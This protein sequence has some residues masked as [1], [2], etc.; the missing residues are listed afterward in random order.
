MS[1]NDKVDQETD[2]AAG[3]SIKAQVRQR[4]GAIAEQYG[5]ASQATPIEFADRPPQGMSGCCGPVAIS[6]DQV[7]QG[8]SCCAPASG[9]EAAATLAEALYHQGDLADL[10]AGVTDVSL[11][12]GNPTAIAQLKPGETVLDLGSGGGIDCFIAAKKVGSAGR[13]IGVDMTGSMLALANQNKARL[14]LTNVEFRKGEIE[15]LPVQNDSVDVVISNCVINLSPDKPAVFGEIYRV[16]KPGGRL[17]VSDIV[18][19]G[20]L[21]PS[22]RANLTAWAECLAGAIDQELYLQQLRQA[23]FVDVAVESRLA[24]GME[25]L[26]LLDEDSNQAITAA[27]AQ[28]AEPAKVGFYSARILARKPLA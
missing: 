16:L 7:A 25:Q 12:C 5:R 28:T 27:L 15:N 2:L 14:G 23:G 21:P 18:T 3:E 26:D 19:E 20:Q 1:S 9:A 22:F 4:Y 17:S 24:Y 6:G 13:A 11:G 8:A 10:P